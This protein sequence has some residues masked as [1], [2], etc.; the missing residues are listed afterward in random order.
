MEFYRMTESTTQPAAINELEEVEAVKQPEQTLEQLNASIEKLKANKDAILNEK[1]ALST[2]RGELQEQLDQA[3]QAKNDLQKRYEQTLLSQ[4]KEKLMSYIGVMKHSR[5]FMEYHIQQN[6]LV[7]LN[8]DEVVYKN[9]RGEIVTLEELKAG[10]VKNDQLK[11]HIKAELPTMGGGLSNGSVGHGG[12]S[13]STKKIN[14][15]NS[16]QFG[17]K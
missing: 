6:E 1:R 10:M 5:D 11:P 14:K 13:Q 2:A 8:G 7:A 4:G 3:T 12:L 9:S 17:L 16:G 15:L